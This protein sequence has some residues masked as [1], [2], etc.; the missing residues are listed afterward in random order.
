MSG[1][2]AVGLT[3]AH[4][5]I[6]AL[7]QAATGSLVAAVWQGILLAAAAG[8]G[9]RLLPRT[10]AAVRFAIWFAVFAVVTALPVLSLLPHAAGQ[11]GGR[12][13]F[14]LSERWCLAIA[15]V[16][17]AA[18]LVRAVSLALAA[19]R[20][21]ALW[22]RA[23]PVELDGVMQAGSRRAQVCTSDEVDRPTVIGFLAPKILIPAWLLEKLTPAELE[24]IVLHE[25]GHLGRADDWMNLLQK[26]ALVMFPLN[27][28]L[29]W[30]ERRLCFERELAVD[31]RVLRTTGAPKAY[32]ECLAT[33]AEY[34]LGRRALALAIGVLGRESELGRRVGRILRR[35][36]VMKPLHSK[37]VLGG[38]M[39]GLL[40]A[41]T[42]FAHCP[43]VVGFARGSS[44]T[45]A[46]GNQWQLTHG[47][48]TAMNGA[49]GLIGT[50]GKAVRALN[51]TY[52]ASKIRQ[53]PLIAHVA[54]QTLAMTSMPVR[55]QAV[56]EQA[57][58]MVQRPVERAASG[59]ARMVQT[60]ARVSGVR[61]ASRTVS[62]VEPSQAASGL[63]TQWVVVTAW[64]NGQATRT[65]FT[66]ATA[67]DAEQ[68]TDAKPDA[69]ASG[70][71]S[72]AESG[73]SYAAVPVRGGWLIFEL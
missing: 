43:Q 18:S 61:N 20:V 66:A 56:D 46:H 29:A 69:A 11:L 32:A 63:V 40:V 30:V 25:A 68:K 37:L 42:G 23:T 70:H 31:E 1:L 62:D 3:Q 54:H 58:D 47:D 19:R 44:S 41:A 35:E 73:P 27:P 65:V 6:T 38:A 71:A 72:P 67:T 10:P 14:V 17:L 45:V 33:L 60:S 51:V 28:A 5:W 21:R 50:N 36:A 8:L 55:Q 13:W 2:A 26:I 49:P 48:E 7:S 59:S 22:K 4:V 53:M 12:A 64:H 34:R 24:Q 52:K 9:L 57:G 16:W 39:L 15:A